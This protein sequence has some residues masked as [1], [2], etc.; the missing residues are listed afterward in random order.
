M[1]KPPIALVTGANS[2]IGLAV[3]QA[4]AQKGWKV[5][6]TFRNPD[7]AQGLVD[8][9]GSLPVVPLRM[10][11]DQASSVREAVHS[12]AEKEEGRVDFLL[13]NAGFVMA[14]FWEDLSDQDLK[15]QFETNVFGLLRVT[16]EILPLMRRQGKGKILNVGSV[17]GLVALPVLGPYSATKFA[18]RSLTEALRMEAGLFGVEVSELAP[19]EIQTAVA[20]NARRAEKALAE[21]SAYSAFTRDFEKFSLERFKQAAPVE[22][23]VKAVM[24]AL[25]DRPMKRRYLVKAEDKAL[26]FLKRFLPDFLLEEA[27]ASQFPWCKHPALKKQVEI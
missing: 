19:S 16:R 3:T 27:L 11:V 22:K 1:D 5:Y 25:S 8:L 9:A 17:G 20:Q 15:A 2:G 4:L 10:D 14:G 26:Y 7:R 24:K 13:N 12:L 21:D 23:M 18:V 6:G